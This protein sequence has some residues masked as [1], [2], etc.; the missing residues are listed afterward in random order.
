MFQTT[1]Q[2]IVDLRE[3]LPNITKPAVY[4]LVNVYIRL[5]SAIEAM[6]QSIASGFSH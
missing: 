2:F 3:D 1:N 6:A 5:P 4:P